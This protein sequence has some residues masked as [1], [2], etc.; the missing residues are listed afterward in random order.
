MV[1]KF[2]LVS[3]LVF[4]LGY[5]QPFDRFKNEKIFKPHFPDSLDYFCSTPA[6]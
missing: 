5:S 3:S 6:K 2:T 1:L 4:N